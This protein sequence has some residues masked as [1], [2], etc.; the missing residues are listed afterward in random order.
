[1]AGI[2]CEKFDHLTGITNFIITPLAFLSG[3]FYSI[4]VLPEYLK[5]LCYLNPVFWLI[6]G[7]RFGTLNFSD[8][9]IFYGIMF[10]L[11]FI[12]LLFTANW[13]LLFRGVRLKN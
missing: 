13:I 6:D 5:N 11:V 3:T 10:T 9:N 8:M 7:A 12:F 2:F 4:N 1:M